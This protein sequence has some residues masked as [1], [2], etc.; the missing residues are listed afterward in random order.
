MSSVETSSAP[1]AGWL[2]G[3]GS[4]VPVG[5]GVGDGACEGHSV[6]V[7]LGAAGAMVGGAGDAQPTISNTTDTVA[8]N[9]PFMLAAYRPVA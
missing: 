8:T 5:R 1:V 6:G 7:G 3:L 2:V 4:G 9:R